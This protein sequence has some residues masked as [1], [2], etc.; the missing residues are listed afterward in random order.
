MFKHMIQVKNL[1]SFLYS[2]LTFDFV[3]ESTVSQPSFKEIGSVPNIPS[4]HTDDSKTM[5]NYC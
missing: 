5:F 3:V 1:F 4:Q 2:Y